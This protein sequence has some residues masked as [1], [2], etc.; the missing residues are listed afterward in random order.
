MSQ[1]RFY[2]PNFD[3][4]YQQRKAR[5]FLRPHENHIAVLKLKRNEPLTKSDLAELERIF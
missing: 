2:K 3:R 5:V 4:A 1:F